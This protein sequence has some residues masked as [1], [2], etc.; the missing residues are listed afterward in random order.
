MKNTNNSE[1]ASKVNPKLG[2]KFMWGP[3][4]EKTSLVPFIHTYIHTYICMYVCMYVCISFPVNYFIL[5][6]DFIPFGKTGAQYTQF[7]VVYG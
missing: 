5:T 3:I 4:G 2:A 7:G 1:G 6:F